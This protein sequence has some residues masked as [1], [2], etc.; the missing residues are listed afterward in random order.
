MTD[1]A[2]TVDESTGEPKRGRPLKEVTAARR[3]QIV[4]L[5]TVDRMTQ[6]EIADQLGITPAAV[7]YHLK[8]ARHGNAIDPNPTPEAGPADD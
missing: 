1:L 3:E 5:R 4:K 6:K 8:R 2:T 7:H